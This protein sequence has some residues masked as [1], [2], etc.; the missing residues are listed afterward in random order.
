MKKGGKRELQTR[1]FTV[2][3]FR[4]LCFFPFLPE[5]HVGPCFFRSST[6][7]ALLI[8]KGEKTR[9]KNGENGKKG[10]RK[11]AKKGYCEQPYCT[12][13]SSTPTS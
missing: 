7:F 11:G 10:V 3:L 5:L 8:E 13:T 1:G 12:N 4:A 6:F 9:A 2:A